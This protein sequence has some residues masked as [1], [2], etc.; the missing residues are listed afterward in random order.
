ME[1]HNKPSAPVNTSE[2]GGSLGT[3]IPGCLEAVGAVPGLTAREVWGKQSSWAAKG[4]KPR[5]E[6]QP[7]AM[8]GRER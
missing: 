3:P 2:R 7:H 1:A 8:L 6:L 5:P 4:R